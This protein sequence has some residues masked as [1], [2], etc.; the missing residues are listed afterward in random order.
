MA[1]LLRS[2]A[3]SHLYGLARPESDLDYYEVHDRS[4]AG[5][6]GKERKT[7]QTIVDGVDVT[8]VGLSHFMDLA[9][10]GS[11]Q[12]LD[13]MFSERTA[14]DEITAMRKGFRVGQH[15]APIYNGIII[16]F[17]LQDTPRKR[18]HAVRLAYNL[19]DM[20][21]TGRFNPTLTPERAQHVLATA[22]LEADDFITEIE[23]VTPYLTI[24]AYNRSYRQ[25]HGK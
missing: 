16:K 21:E 10:S 25:L 18:K 17:A 8:A 15:I 1:L 3:G 5:N 9:I 13:A 7:V 24:F 19:H 20:M 22:E 23:K 14:V 4:L 6:L 12:A 11:H 2:F